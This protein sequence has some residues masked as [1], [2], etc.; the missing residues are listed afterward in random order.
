[1]QKRSVGKYARLLLI[2]AAL[3][4]SIA[5]AGTAM[6]VTSN[7][8]NYQITETQIGGGSSLESCSDQYCAQVTIGDVGGANSSSSAEFGSINTDEPLIE[9]IIEPGESNLGVLTTETT[10]TK[11]TLVKVRSILSGGYALQIVGDPPKFEDHTLSASTTPIES[12][13]GT[14]QFGINVVA[15]TQPAVG[16]MPA[17]VPEG[18]EIFGEAA[19]GY[20]TPNFFKFVDGDVVGQG[21]TES[22]RTDYTI[23]MIVNISSA[24]PAG[25]Y[26]GD[27]MAIVVPVY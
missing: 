15:N 1:M 2:G 13:P 10:A 7:S 12:R 24:T 8:P 17:Q 23:T 5:M 9:V 6:A 16:A 26:S 11:T 4:G 18:A 22:G 3:V 19:P 14:E 27:F 25:K 21:I 20:N